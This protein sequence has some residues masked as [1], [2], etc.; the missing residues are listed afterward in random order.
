MHISDWSIDRN[1][2]FRELY[3]D[4]DGAEFILEW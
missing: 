3:C 4:F 2:I 1:S